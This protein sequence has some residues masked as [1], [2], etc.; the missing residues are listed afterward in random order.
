MLKTFLIGLGGLVG[1]IIRYWLTGLLARQ[2]GETL[3]WGTIAVNLIGCFLAG[4]VFHVTEERMMLDPTARAVIFV[5]LFGG[6]TTFSAY[7]LQTFVLLR[8]GHFGLAVLNICAANL[9]GLLLVWAG[10]ALGKAV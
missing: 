9:V 8:D 5:G 2:Y 1:T 7:G 10:Y 3:P 6:F 4:V